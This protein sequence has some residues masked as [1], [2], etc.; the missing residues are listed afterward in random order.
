ML[1]GERFCPSSRRL[2]GSRPIRLNPSRDEA[3]TLIDARAL[4]GELSEAGPVSLPAG[5]GLSLRIP[6]HEPGPALAVVRAVCERNPAIL[7]AC[8]GELDSDR[9]GADGAADAREVTALLTS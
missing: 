8:W 1:K 6:D 2:E 9:R 5:T 4:F 7:R 3:P